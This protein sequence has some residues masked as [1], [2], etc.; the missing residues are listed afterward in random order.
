MKVLVA[1][2]Y[3]R[4]ISDVEIGEEDFQIV[5][6]FDEDTPEERVKEIV[7]Q[8]MN[9]YSDA[10]KRPEYEDKDLGQDDNA[11]ISWSTE[12]VQVMSLR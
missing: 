9:L 12:L 7:L 1:T 4:D 6:A 11:R 10:F 2:A 8:E 5:L 3:P